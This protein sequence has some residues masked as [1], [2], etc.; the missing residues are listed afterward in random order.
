M[1]IQDQF[2]QLE[3]R[4]IVAEQR[5]QIVYKYLQE[6]GVNPRD[7]YTGKKTSDN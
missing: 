5:L 3:S 2:N 6:S 4:A 7:V 1:E